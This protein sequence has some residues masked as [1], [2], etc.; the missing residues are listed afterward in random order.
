M[1]RCAQA[2]G[3]HLRHPHVHTGLAKAEDKSR[4]YRAKKQEGPGPEDVRK[5]V[6]APANTVSKE[7][8]APVAH[9]TP[10][11]GCCVGGTG[12]ILTVRWLLDHTDGG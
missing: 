9:S 2:L 5:K 1:H 4:G 11:G 7:A 10:G 12:W 3:P 8:P 6:P